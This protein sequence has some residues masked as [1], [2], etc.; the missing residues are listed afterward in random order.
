MVSLIKP[1]ICVKNNIIT[2]IC[3]Y[4]LS[5]Q[6]DFCSETEAIHI[7]VYCITFNGHTDA[8]IHNTYKLIRWHWQGFIN[9][10]YQ[11]GGYWPFLVNLITIT[12]ANKFK[13]MHSHY[14]QQHRSYDLCQKY[15]PDILNLRSNSKQCQVMKCTANAHNNIPAFDCGINIRRS[16]IRCLA[17]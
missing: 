14:W 11:A 5:I 7:T 6:A 10:C 1:C 4:F 8:M 13:S 15:T 3:N 16:F 12:K 17:L 2:G 9:M